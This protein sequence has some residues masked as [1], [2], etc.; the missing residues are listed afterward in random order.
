[1]CSTPQQ[2]SVSESIRR[3]HEG[4]FMNATVEFFNPGNETCA[5][6]TPG[7]VRQMLGPALSW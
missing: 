7:Q 2:Y 3:A 6:R 4:S 1:M 5:I